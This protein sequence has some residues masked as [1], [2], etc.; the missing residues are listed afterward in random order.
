[1]EKRLRLFTKRSISLLVMLSILLVPGTILATLGQSQELPA[2]QLVMFQDFENYTNDFESG[3][4][5]D[6]MPTTD[7]SQV[8]SGSASGVVDKSGDSGSYQAGMWQ[9]GYRTRRNTEY[10]LTFKYKIVS[11][12][13]GSR[14]YMIARTDSVGSGDDRYIFLNNSNDPQGRSSDGDWYNFNIIDKGGYRHV[15]FSFNSGDCDDRYLMWGVHGTG[16]ITI[17]DVALYIGNAGIDRDVLQP[18]AENP[19]KTYVTQDFDGAVSNMVLSGGQTQPVYENRI[20]GTASLAGRAGSSWTFAETRS[21]LVPISSWGIHT[22]TFK[23]KKQGNL[24][25]GEFYHFTA[26]SPTG[27]SEAGYATDRYFRWD[28]NGT[29]FEAG[30]GDLAYLSQLRCG[31]FAVEDYWLV[32]LTFYVDGYHDYVLQ[33]GINSADPENL[34]IL[35]DIRVFYGKDYAHDPAVNKTEPQALWQ[36]DFEDGIPAQLQ[37][38]NGALVNQAPKI[39]NGSVSYEAATAP[40]TL[41]QMVLKTDPAKLTLLPDTLYTITL[42]L[43]ALADTG[44][45]YQLATCT[46]SHSQDNVIRMNAQ[47]ADAGSFNLP[48]GYQVRME[49]D[50]LYLSAVFKTGSEPNQRFEINIYDGGSMILDDFRIFQ[51][52]TAAPAGPVQV[53][54]KDAIPVFIER[55]ESQDTALWNLNPL[56]GSLGYTENE[57]IN[58]SYSYVSRH[59]GGEYYISMESM[60][61]RFAFKPNTKY[62]VLFRYRN[63]S[64]SGQYML[65]AKTENGGYLNDQFVRFYA[66]GSAVPGVGSNA[67]IHAAAQ[68]DYYNARVTF[69]TGDYSD[70]RIIFC[71]INQGDIVLD[72]FV[73]FEGEFFAEDS[74]PVKNIITVAPLYGEDFESANPNSGSFVWKNGDIAFKDGS[75]INGSY[76]FHLHATPDQY[77]YSIPMESNPAKTA[78]QVGSSYTVQMRWKRISGGESDYMMLAFRGPAGDQYIKLRTDG[79]KAEG[80]DRSY[81]VTRS[82]EIYELKVTFTLSGTGPYNLAIVYQNNPQIILDDLYVYEGFLVN[83][84]PQIYVTVPVIQPVLR[85]DFENHL[86]KGTVK[87]F[88]ENGAYIDESDKLI[89]G[90]IS[91]EAKGSQDGVYTKS[92]SSRTLPLTASQSATVFLRFQKAQMQSP[93]GFYQF[94][95]KTPAGGPLNDKYI[96]FDAQGNVVEGN[97]SSLKVNRVGDIFEVTMAFQLAGFSDYEFAMYIYGNGSVVVDDVE[98]YSGMVADPQEVSSGGD[99][100]PS[101]IIHENFEG[102]TSL[103]EL[104]SGSY[105]IKDA[106]LLSGSTSLQVRSN[107]DEYGYTIA[108]SSKRSGLTF[109]NEGV[110]TV[111]MRYRFTEEPA[112]NGYAMLALRTEQGGPLND[113]FI[114]FSSSSTNLES[115]A[116]SVK[117]Q[118]LEGEVL[119]TVTFLLE[120]YAD[121]R[122][123]FVLYGSK[124]TLCVDDITV[125]R[126]VSAN[127]MNPA[128]PAP[129]TPEQIGTYKVLDEDFEHRGSLG[130]LFY[131]RQGVVVFEEGTIINGSFSVAMTAPAEGLWMDAF[132]SNMDVLQLKPNQTYSLVFRFRELAPSN[133]G[134]V[135]VA[136]RI[137][138]GDGLGDSFVRFKP[139]G[140]YVDGNAAYELLYTSDAYQTAVFAFTTGEDAM[141]LVFSMFSSGGIYLDDLSLFEST[142]Y[143]YTTGAPVVNVPSREVD[144]EDYETKT[145]SGLYTVPDTTVPGYKAPANHSVE[146]TGEIAT[147]PY[148]WTEKVVTKETITKE[149][150]Y[151]ETITTDA[152]IQKIIRKLI[153]KSSKQTTVLI[154]SISGAAALG[155]ALGVFFLIRHR[156][157]KQSGSPGS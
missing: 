79:T 105:G 25:P 41:W 59:T 106:A 152:V 56:G 157:R 14:F 143:V 68:G 16:R 115:N 149:E 34:M 100:Q 10:T 137:P 12:T 9:I 67:S 82:G 46:D 15:R 61:D 53:V 26:S 51:G 35:D 27:R 37:I 55:F 123:E 133:G 148:E 156:K 74:E 131:L 86:S 87:V 146:L 145:G 126:S 64:E 63:L 43:K 76:S 11:L 110:Y 72:D 19:G 93:G 90:N 120:N 73:I 13:P 101:L 124:G 6:L 54:E 65:A 7:P 44:G 125:Y 88:P 40:G 85:E 153:P 45:Y 111:S 103:F 48:F 104:K 23:M 108:A 113:R 112:A 151:E 94:A 60:T 142:A 62:H 97:H 52:I 18:V 117:S 154:L 129:K 119:L 130:E 96:R 33:W 75:I 31:I 132:V 92:L 58:G 118:V 17:D 3:F 69:T 49:D 24:A 57:V 102:P 42:R 141:E 114:R 50:I 109:D 122:L 144:G 98:I 128:A 39:I 70:Y 30:T 150:P 4:V 135:Q 83:P 47:G 155:L 29:I 8:I 80:N 134:F 89:S 1:M 71:S 22:V 138:G 78:Y 66:D 38:A 28:N 2:P 136:A 77:G 81:Q 116:L 95:L 121:Y 20:N 147:D 91:Y 5:S 99:V 139:D 21:D 140:T 36:F 127:K 84:L 32:K 107:P